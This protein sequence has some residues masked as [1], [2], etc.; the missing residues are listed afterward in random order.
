VPDSVA[1]G[2]SIFPPQGSEPVVTIQ[3][4]TVPALL[5]SPNWTNSL[6]ARYAGGMLERPPMP[7]FACWALMNSR[8]FS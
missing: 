8:Q 2:M 3:L 4:T 7:A 5:P 6:I 1:T